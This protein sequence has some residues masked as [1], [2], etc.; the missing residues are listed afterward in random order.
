MPIGQNP[1]LAQIRSRPVPTPTFFNG[2]QVAL[3]LIEERKILL[4]IAE[5]FSLLTAIQMRGEIN[6]LHNQRKSYLDEANRLR[7]ECSSIT[8]QIDD[9]KA[10][11]ELQSFG[12]F[13]YEHPA[14]NSVTLNEELRVLRTRIKE[15]VKNK[16]ATR[17]ATGFMFDGSEA[18]GRRFV[19]NM[20]KLMLR[21]YNAEAENAVK[22]VKSEKSTAAI[23][24]LNKCREQIEKLGSMIELSITFEYHRDRVREIELA[25]E[26][27]K[28]L[29]YEK[30]K[31]REEAERLREERKVEAELKAR[32]DVLARERDQKRL[33]LQQLQEFQKTNPLE[34]TETDREK[35]E[36]LT[37]EVEDIEHSLEEAIERAANLQAGYVYVISNRGS[38]GENVVKIGMT[39]RIDPMDRVKE[40][41]SASVPFTFD[42]HLIHYSENALKIEKEL[43]KIFARDRVNLMNPRKEHFYTTPARV[44]D[45]ILKL[46]G[47]ITTFNETVTAQD[48]VDSVEQRKLMANA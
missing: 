47:S 12:I 26:Y 36:V 19:E 22:S 2:K 3:Q 14:K 31:A 42:V 21:A 39:R 28:V 23:N 38:F 4:G 24:R 46:D 20:T 1:H 34:V 37:A 40:L 25:F 10:R 16:R 32:Q 8:S 9:A 17:S 41:G 13:D 43:H 44:R 11:V 27:H 18:K 45:E 5:E 6:A 7:S 33:A 35:L 29:R 48:Y 15:A 30:E